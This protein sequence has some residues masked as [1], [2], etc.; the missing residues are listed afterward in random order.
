MSNR[1][2]ILLYCT[3]TRRRLRRQWREEIYC[4]SKVD[5]FLFRE[6]SGCGYTLQVIAAAAEKV[7]K[8]APANAAAEKMMAVGNEYVNEDFGKAVDALTRPKGCKNHYTW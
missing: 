5:L 2:C 3:I 8:E 4:Y 6:D 7:D 1:C